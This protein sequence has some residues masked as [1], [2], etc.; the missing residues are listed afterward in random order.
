MPQRPPESTPALC[1]VAIVLKQRSRLA[2]APTKAQ[3]GGQTTGKPGTG[4]LGPGQQL[5]Q[6]PGR[7]CVP[8]GPHSLL[9]STR[10]ARGPRTAR[11]ALPT[12]PQGDPP[13]SPARPIPQGRP[14]QGGSSEHPRSSTRGQAGRV[15]RG[16]VSGDT[17]DIW[18]WRHLLGACSLPAATEEKQVLHSR[19]GGAG[20]L[21]G[22]QVAVQHH[23]QGVRLAGA[24]AG[25]CVL[26]EVLHDQGQVGETWRPY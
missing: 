1:G 19:D 14:L 20:V 11:S 25:P 5:P 8:P 13:Q 16:R 24:E 7:L 4:P 17:Q 22:D 2:S 23:V 6:L 3:R 26:H 15:S 9:W 21:P 10:G 12:P 18:R